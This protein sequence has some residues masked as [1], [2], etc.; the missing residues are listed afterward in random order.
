MVG[1]LYEKFSA[2]PG[3]P[4]SEQSRE[5]L[6][7]KSGRPTPLPSS[8]TWIHGFGWRFGIYNGFLTRQACGLYTDPAAQNGNRIAGASSLF[9]IALADPNG[10]RPALEHVLDCARTELNGVE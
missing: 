3:D 4:R 1:N 5:K 8:A 7:L 2:R 6:H 9:A 10:I